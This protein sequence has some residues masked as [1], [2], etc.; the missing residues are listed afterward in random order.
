MQNNINKSILN[1]KIVSNLN[2][3]I[4]KTNSKYNNCMAWG[5]ALDTCNTESLPDFYKSSIELVNLLI[6]SNNDVTL[7]SDIKKNYFIKLKNKI[8]NTNENTNQEIPF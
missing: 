1:E 7:E 3:S 5:S 8:D 4:E 6:D 2:K